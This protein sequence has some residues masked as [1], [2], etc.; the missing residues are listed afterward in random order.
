MLASRYSRR[1]LGCVF[2]LALCSFCVQSRAASHRTACTNPICRN[3]R[4]FVKAHY[5]G[6]SPFGNGPADSCEIVLQKNPL[7]GN[8]SIADF[9]CE[10]ADQGQAHCMQRGVPSAEIRAGLLNHM[11]AIGLSKQNDNAVLFSD[12]ISN[13]TGW[14]LIEAYY[15]QNEGNEL[16]VCQVIA[17]YEPGQAIRWVR[18]V[19]F[20]KTDSDVPTVTLWSP[21]SIAQIN[22]QQ[23][24]ILEGDAYEDHWLEAIT[25]L[26]G[27]AVTVFSGLGYFL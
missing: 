16:E 23:T 7:P 17:V 9:K 4:A 22:G 8:S 27:H 10:W 25:I 15:Q 21:I 11:H 18:T 24:F 12:L 13:S 6:K 3:V 5:C 2:L 19:P 26:D 20:Q 14:H 1:A